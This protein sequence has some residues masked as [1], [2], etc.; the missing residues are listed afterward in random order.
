MPHTPTRERE[1][2][3]FG[4][5]ESP[6][7]CAELAES[8]APGPV[9]LA[10]YDY[11]LPPEL[12]AQ[13][14][15]A[16]RDAARLLCLERTGNALRHSR[17]DELPALLRRGDLLVF[18]DTRV[19]PARLACRSETGGA[20]E[21]L[22][23]APAADGTWSCLG[24][25]AKRL[26]PGMTLVLPGE[27]GT[28]RVRLRT[29]PGRYAIQLPAGVDVPALLDAAGELPLPPY[30]RRPH[31]PEP[32]DRE[33]YQTIYA[34]RDG[35]V[36]APTAGLHFTAELLAALEA[37]GIERAFLTLAVGPATFLPLRVEDARAHDLEPE[38]A[39]IPA[40]TVAAIERARAAGGRVI[41]VG[42]TTVRA[43][44]SAARRPGGLTSGAFAAEAFILPPFTFRV[45]DGLLTNFHLPRSTLLMLVS[46]FAGRE[47]V[48]AAYGQAVAARYRV[49]SYGDAML[50]C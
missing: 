47:R 18:N 19:R 42:T 35:A 8:R 22:V 12:I 28:A 25:P 32:A 4:G 26:R 33:R 7:P 14:P 34:A 24:R 16:R 23:L 44:E 10:D 2:P 46:A 41:A 48:L 21:L 30:I 49:Y 29:A 1:Q 40:A 15:A 38:W 27:W 39:E 13:A 43:L 5:P 31:G 11:D 9:L 37:A 20:V 36:A 3:R 45:V 17:V 6:V 50:I